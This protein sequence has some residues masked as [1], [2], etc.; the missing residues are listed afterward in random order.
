MNPDL[1]FVFGDKA[2]GRDSSI[3]EG[4]VKEISN[5]EQL[6]EVTNNEILKE[7]NP[8]APLIMGETKE[9]VKYEDVSVES[10]GDTGVDYETPSVMV[11]SEAGESGQSVEIT[12]HFTIHANSADDGRDITEKIKRVLEEQGCFIFAVS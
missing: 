9:A 5:T 7:V 8:P 1:E 3:G 11:E 10:G 12:N 2:I 4:L 6:K